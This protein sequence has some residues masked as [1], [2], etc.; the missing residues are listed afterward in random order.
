[1]EPNL[2]KILLIENDA[3]STRHIKDLLRQGR[4]AEF[5]LTSVAELESGLA[6]LADTRFDLVL[7]DLLLPD[8]GGLG[9]INRLQAEAP[10]VPVIVLGHLDDEAVALEAVHEGAQDYLVRSQL[11]P[12]FL[13]RAIRYAVERERADAALLEAE[14][15]YRGIFE[16]IVEGIFQTSPDGQYLSANSALARIYGY[17]SPDELINSVRDIGRK[18]YVDPDR[19]TEFIQTMQEHDIVTDFE[20]RIHRKDG[21]IIW[22]AENVRAIRDAKGRLLYY[23]GTV[24][25]ITQRKMAQA[26][27]HDSEALYHSLVETL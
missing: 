22:I 20:S 15:K 13:S 23:E 19:R 3:D 27:L 12:Q 6:R 5:E 17:S 16:H 11:N 1:M 9:N 14:E 25:D 21:S 26:R 2:L 7:M 8:G 10:R 24:E 18:L 4:G